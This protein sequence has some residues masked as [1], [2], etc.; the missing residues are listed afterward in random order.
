M[1]GEGMAGDGRGLEG[2]GRGELREGERMRWE[3]G[4]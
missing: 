2:R 3:M 1:G 4:S